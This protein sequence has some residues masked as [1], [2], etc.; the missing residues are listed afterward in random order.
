MSI[1]RLFVEFFRLKNA[2]KISFDYKTLRFS[3]G[4]IAF[5]LPIVVVVIA[6]ADLGSIS[7]AYHTQSRNI[8]VGLLFIVGAFLW[9][10]RGHYMYE[11]WLARTASVCA[12]LTALAPTYCVDINGSN[13]CNASTIQQGEIH[14]VS[15]AV[16]FL[17]LTIFCWGPFR[18]KAAEKTGRAVM[19]KWIYIICGAL[20][21]A[22]LCAIAVAFVWKEQFAAGQLIFFAEWIA[23]WAFGTAWITAGQYFSALTNENEAW[24]LW[25]NRCKRD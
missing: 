22:A 9:A 5:T 10:Y 13:F 21:L 11:V 12:F 3:V 18:A 7:M 19:R 4:V 1:W 20:M 15:A 17:M 6:G 8:F 14:N 23:L 24:N 16:L 25:G 2:D